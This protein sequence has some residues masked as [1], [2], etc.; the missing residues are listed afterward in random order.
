[1]SVVEE[2]VEKIEDWKGK[3]ISIQPLSGGLINSNYK[4]IGRAHV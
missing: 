2:A 3:N 1:M 4:E